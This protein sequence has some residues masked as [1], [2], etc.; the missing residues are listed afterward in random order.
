MRRQ[1]HA[2][3]EKRQLDRDPGLSEQ[4]TRL[5]H[6]QLYEPLNGL[7]GKAPFFR[8][9]PLC[10]SPKRLAASAATSHCCWYE[11]GP[12]VRPR[13]RGFSCSLHFASQPPAQRR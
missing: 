5:Q 7:G 9:F 6:G 8:T 2:D 1:R 12:P 11:G 4:P 13:I 3:V 10:P